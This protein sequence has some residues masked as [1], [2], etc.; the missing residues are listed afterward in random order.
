MQA[1]GGVVAYAEQYSNHSDN[2]DVL[3]F[4]YNIQDIGWQLF[5][6]QE[7]TTWIIYMIKM[8]VFRDEFMQI[9]FRRKKEATVNHV[10]IEPSET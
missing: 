2:G 5:F 1:I 6:I 10:K 4:A 8:K 7:S 9:V 3:M